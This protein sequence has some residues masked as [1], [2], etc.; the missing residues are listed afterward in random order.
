MVIVCQKIP[1]L[2]GIEETEKKRKE[3]KIY[4]VRKT[5]TIY[6]FICCSLGTSWDIVVKQIFFFLVGQDFSK[7]IFHSTYDLDFAC[8]P[9]FFSYH[10]SFFLF[11]KLII[12]EFTRE[13]S[14]VF[15]IPSVCYYFF[16]KLN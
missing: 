9:P 4:I 6:T 14:Q 16:H 12:I 8:Q 10:F 11:F 3:K 5:N 2:K 15:R 13:S 1:S 7:K